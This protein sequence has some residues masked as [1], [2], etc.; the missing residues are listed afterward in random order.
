[1]TQLQCFIRILMITHWRSVT[2]HRSGILSHS[3]KETSK[4]AFSKLLS[5]YMSVV[6]MGKYGFLVRS[7]VLHFQKVHC[8]MKRHH[9]ALL[10]LGHPQ[11][12]LISFIFDYF[13]SKWPPFLCNC[14]YNEWI[15]PNSILA[16]WPMA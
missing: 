15:D 9:T 12:R 4:F 7:N 13:Y 2:F 6:L 11:T 14:C 1:M 16:G 3:A 5:I 10:S 8:H